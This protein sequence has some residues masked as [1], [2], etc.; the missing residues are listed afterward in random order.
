MYSQSITRNHRAAFLIAIDLS[1]SMSERIVT[2]DGERPKAE[3]AC[4]ITNSLIFELIERA[5]RCDGVRDYY[6]ISV[7]GY[8]G[9]G[10]FPLIGQDWFIRVEQ[11]AK[12]EPEMTTRLVSRPTPDGGVA[13]Q[14]LHQP[15]WIKPMAEGQTPMYEL[16]CRLHMLV[17]EWCGDPRHYKS[18]PPVIFHI[19]DG[20]ASDC[21]EQSLLEIT[22]AIRSEGTEDGGVLLLNCHLSSNTLLPATIF[23]TTIEE[24]GENRYG[25]LL[26]ACSS[27]L[28]PIFDEAIR[29]VRGCNCPGPFR[30]MSYNSTIHELIS[31]LNIG[32]ISLP[33]H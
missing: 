3:V 12:I 27:E 29:S 5:R 19:T 1:T 15:V 10:V 30:G 32:S 20:E 18:F 28:P 23:P 6:D 13:L 16:F 22:R 21:D 14:R 31:L 7:V 9:R 11:L 25:R 33:I 4:E 17:K 24:L 8:S 26:Y 2:P